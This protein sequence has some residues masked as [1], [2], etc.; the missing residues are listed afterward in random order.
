M[1]ERERRSAY[2]GKFERA[3]SDPVVLDLI[4]FAQSEPD[5]AVRCGRWDVIGWIIQSAKE[6]AASEEDN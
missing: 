4:A 3:L 1:S 6:P 5:P 2:A